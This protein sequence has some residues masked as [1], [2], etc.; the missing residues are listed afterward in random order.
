MSLGIGSS[1]AYSSEL[2]FDV[3]VGWFPRF[4]CLR[5]IDKTSYRDKNCIAKRRSRL[6]DTSDPRHALSA[7]SKYLQNAFAIRICSGV[8]HSGSNNAGEH[9]KMLKAFACVATFNRFKLYRKPM[10]R[11]ASACVE[12]VME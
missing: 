12:V 3:R 11:G 4:R 7:I 2:V 9:T 5:I 10:P 8:Q 1:E 6:M